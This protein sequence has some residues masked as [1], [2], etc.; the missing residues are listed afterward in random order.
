MS[1][2]AAFGLSM[3]CFAVLAW[4]LVGGATLFSDRLN[5]AHVALHAAGLAL[6]AAF[7]AQAW[8]YAWVWWI[9]AFF[10]GLPAL[11]EAAAIYTAAGR[12][13]AAAGKVE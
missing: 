3:V 1:F 4:G 8:P 11:A 13:A 2:N 6:T 5:G 10:N 9:W 7:I 12:G